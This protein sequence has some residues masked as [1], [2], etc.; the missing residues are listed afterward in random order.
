MKY[1]LVV[2][3]ELNKCQ[4]TSN[5]SRYVAIEKT[6]GIP[7]AAEKS[8]VMWSLAKPVLDPPLYPV[9]PFC[10]AQGKAASLPMYRP[11]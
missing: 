3:P 1:S 11:I 8:G 2:V 10:A 5:V 7:E 9:G 6:R 4:L